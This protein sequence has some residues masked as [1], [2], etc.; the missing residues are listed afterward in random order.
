MNPNDP[1]FPE[2][3]TTYDRDFERDIVTSTGGLSIRAY[4]ATAA[5]PIATQMCHDYA[6][7]PAAKELARAA[8]QLADAL[9]AELNKED[10]K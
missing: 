1:A 9:I 8:V 2:V 7:E 4:I 5:L 10:S 6:S 3:E